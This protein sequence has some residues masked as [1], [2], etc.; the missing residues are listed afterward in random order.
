MSGK[1]PGRASCHARV[2]GRVVHTSP[3]SPR[4]NDEGSTGNSVVV[5]GAVHS[6]D[7]QCS[8]RS[9]ARTCEATPVDAAG[10]NHPRLCFD[11]VAVRH[12]RGLSTP[13]TREVHSI[14]G[15]DPHLARM[16]RGGL[17]TCS[18]TPMRFRDA[19]LSPS[20]R[21]APSRRSSTFRPLRRL[22]GSASGLIN[23]AWPAA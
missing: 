17:G 3:F 19:S 22:A 18:T 20:L 2:R 11:G 5:V 13:L 16:W 21:S 9:A 14:R 1:K 4:L 10:V 15:L 7:N 12:P 8:C 6:V 23:S